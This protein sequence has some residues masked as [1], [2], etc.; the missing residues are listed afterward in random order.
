MSEGLRRM[1]C[2]PIVQD[3][4]PPDYKSVREMLVTKIKTCDA[5]VHMAGFYYGAEPL[6][7]PAEA[8]RRS[9]TQMEYE[10]AM[11]LK[12]PCYVFLC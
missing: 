7:L 11:E 2:L 4:F 9:F 8:D 5:V 1:E 12:L 6:P 3:D 10:I